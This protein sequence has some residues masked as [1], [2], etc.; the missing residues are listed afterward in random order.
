MEIGRKIRSISICT[1]TALY[2][3]WKRGRGERF[4]H[5]F[6]DKFRFDIF[7]NRPKGKRSYHVRWLIRRLSED[8]NWIKRRPIQVHFHSVHL[9]INFY[10]HVPVEVYENVEESEWRKHPKPKCFNFEHWDR[11]CSQ[12]RSSLTEWIAREPS[13]LLYVPQLKSIFSWNFHSELSL[14][15]W[16]NFADEN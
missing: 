15:Y 16:P 5:N 6:R 4:Y 11:W 8:F 1:G 10:V 2:S 7:S 13:I 14:N 3:E 9:F 12:R